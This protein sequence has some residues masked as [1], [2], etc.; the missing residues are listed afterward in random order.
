MSVNVSNG[1]QY[2]YRSLDSVNKGVADQLSPG[3]LMQQPYAVAAQLLDGMTTI[4]RAWYTRE[5]QV[6]PLTFKLSKEQM[7]KDNERD[8]NMAKIMTSLMFCPKMAWRLGPVVS[9][10][11][12]TGRNV[13]PRHIRAQNSRRDAGTT[14]QPKARSEN[15]KASSSRRIPI[16]SNVPLWARGF[17]NAIHAFGEA[18]D[19]NN[20]AKANID[21]T[22]EAN[23][24]NENQ[25][26]NDNTPSTDA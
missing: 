1:S 6:S 17:I 24:N 15:K 13:P 7:E 3:G 22:T 8:Q 11:K 10:P 14:D 16:D 18:H 9:I 4:N 5:D 19:L 23:T 20:M 2:F 25:S 21:T 12:V 26:R